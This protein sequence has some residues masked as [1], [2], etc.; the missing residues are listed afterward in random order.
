MGNGMQKLIFIVD[1]NDANLTM[2]ASVLD[3]GYKVLT[4]PSAEKMF[5]LLGKKRPDMILLDN[6]MP[7]MSGLEALIKLKENP[8]WKE[9]PVVFLTGWRDENLLSDVIKA[10]ALEIV[11][12]PIVPSILIDCVKKYIGI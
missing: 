2:A 7:E 8:Q 12:K 10:G 6:E 4:V 5:T 9:I 11:D 3:W 1:D